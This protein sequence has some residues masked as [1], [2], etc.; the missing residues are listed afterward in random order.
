MKTELLVETLD[1]LSK[2]SMFRLSLTSKELFHSNFWAWMVN[3]YPKETTKVF[4]DAYDGKSPVRVFR[5]KKNFDLLL[6]IGDLSV[7]I[8]NKF[9]SFPD[10]KQL[11]D[12]EQKLE[13]AGQKNQKIILISY[14]PP[15]F[16]MKE[17]W[18]Y[19]SY[20]DLGKRLKMINFN[21]RFSTEDIA[22]IKTY[23]EC[24]DCLNAIKESFILNSNKD[25]GAFWLYLQDKDLAEKIDEINFSV[26]IQKNYIS[27]VARRIADKLDIEDL[28]VGLGTGSSHVAYCDFFLKKNNISLGINLCGVDYRY[29]IG[30]DNPKKIPRIEV[31]N[32]LDENYGWFF[33]KGEGQTRNNKA[34]HKYYGFDGPKIWLY[35]KVN[36]SDL[37]IEDL[38]GKLKSDLKEIQNCEK[39]VGL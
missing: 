21:E 10:K 13:S 25:Y 30:L 3:K 11:E 35:K 9:K 31:E 16:K 5:E 2:N 37:S 20:E 33:D 26:T 28:S 27:E 32:F 34:G 19:L 1:R 38:T 7:V 4:Y 36:V 22:I 29:I 23:A 15:V 24:I 8:E 14:Y 18:E 39:V 6:E 12:Y 17:D